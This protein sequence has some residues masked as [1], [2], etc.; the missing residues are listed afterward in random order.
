MGKSSLNC[1][2][3]K[4]CIC[5]IA[6]ILILV[7]VTVGLSVHFLKS[8]NPVNYFNSHL[9]PPARSEVLQ[10]RTEEGSL[11]L[12]LTVENA[13][14]KS[15]WDSL[16]K[17][18]VEKW[19]SAAKDGE[20]PLKLTVVDRVVHHDFDCKPKRGRL[21]ICDGDYGDTDWYGLNAVLLQDGYIVHSTIK[22]NDY[23]LSKESDARRKYI[24]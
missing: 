19:D 17:E 12:A 24:M 23:H 11:G 13:L 2:G 14:D 8:P 5:L 21:K 4:L 16:F 20:D 7:G 9:D 22:L 6:T 18:Y 15:E 10:W 1:C 3:K